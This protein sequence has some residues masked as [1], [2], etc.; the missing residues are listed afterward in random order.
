MGTKL[1][2]KEIKEITNGYT[3]MLDVC[4]LCE[5]EEVNNS[6]QSIDPTGMSWDVVCDECMSGATIDSRY[7]LT[8]IQHNNLEIDGYTLHEDH[9]L[10]TIYFSREGAN[11]SLFATPNWTEK[12]ITPIELITHDGDS[13][14]LGELRMN[15]LYGNLTA[16]VE[17]YLKGVEGF[18]NIAE[19]VA[20]SLVVKN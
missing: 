12:G 3:T 11:Y 2:E 4:L 5:G 6:M 15:H 19:I 10:G 14:S 18:L 1:T 13:F 8:H 16:Q 9:A 7:L 17:M 20:K